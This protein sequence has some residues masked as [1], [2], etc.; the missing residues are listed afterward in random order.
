MNN[1]PVMPID[2]LN[3]VVPLELKITVVRDRYLCGFERIRQ[4]LRVIEQY[5]NEMPI[6]EIKANDTKIAESPRAEMKVSMKRLPII[7]SFQVPSEGTYTVIAIE[8]SKELCIYLVADGSN[9]IYRCKIKALG[10]AD[11]EAFKHVDTQRTLAD[12]LAIIGTLEVVFG[13]IYR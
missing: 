10:C 12:V 1:C 5:L 3:M 6:G 8:A 9:R 4:S 7:L 11:L 2:N 13:E